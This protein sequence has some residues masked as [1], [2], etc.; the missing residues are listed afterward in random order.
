MYGAGD[1]GGTGGAPSDCGG[2]VI[3]GDGCV[4][5]GGG[6]VVDGGGAVVDGGGAV[7]DGGGAVVDFVPDSLAGGEDSLFPCDCS[8]LPNIILTN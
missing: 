5:S 1:G 3:V 7:V 4:V 8:T 2:I 6:V